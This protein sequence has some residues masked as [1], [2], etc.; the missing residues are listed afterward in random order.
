[1]VN[2]LGYAEYGSLEHWLFS[3]LHYDALIRSTRS[4]GDLCLYQTVWQLLMLN[5]LGYAEYGSLE[6]WLFSHIPYDALIRSTLVWWWPLPVPDC[7]ATVNVELL[8]RCWIWV[9]IG[10]SVIFLMMLWSGLP[11]SDGDLRHHSLV[12]AFAQHPIAHSG[13][14]CLPGPYLQRHDCPGR[15]LLH[16][17][18]LES[19]GRSLCCLLHCHWS[20]VYIEFF[21]LFVWGVFG[22]FFFKL[23]KRLCLACWT[24]K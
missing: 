20:V 1:M 18:S 4:D 13:H 5:S 2:S 15:L 8:W 22:C 16:Q 9:S 21:C 3:H 24:F 12:P 10:S 23:E 17:G 6:L 7:L 11:W 19:G 14:L